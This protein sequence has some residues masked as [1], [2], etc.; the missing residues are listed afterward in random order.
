MGST[1]APATVL[2]PSPTPIGSRKSLIFVTAV[3]IALRLFHYLRDPSVW[4]DE[5]ALVVNVLN[6]N[7]AQLLGPL[8]WHEA[9]PPLFLWLERAV[10]L[11]LGDS[12]YAL[13]LIP[14]LASCVS[15]VLFSIVDAMTALYAGVCDTA[16]VVS[17]MLR[18]PGM[19]RSAAND[20]FRRSVRNASA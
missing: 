12:T 16:L 6:L 20:P 17:S 18:L 3:G 8:M 10:T 15:V 2:C 9:S 7:F 13:R 5:A 14:V 19:S 11:V 4:H 1:S